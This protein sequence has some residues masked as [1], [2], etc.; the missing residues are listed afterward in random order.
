[1]NFLTD[2]DFAFGGGLVEQTGGRRYKSGPGAKKAIPKKPRLKLRVVDGKLKYVPKKLRKRSGRNIF[3]SEY[4]KKNN[5]SGPALMKKGNKA[6]DDLSKA[7]KQKFEDR[8]DAMGYKPAA[9][10]RQ[11]AQKFARKQSPTRAGAKRRSPTRKSPKRKSKS[12]KR[13]SP[14]RKSKSPKRKSPKRRKSPRRKTPKGKS[15]RKR[16]SPRKQRGGSSCGSDEYQY[17]AGYGYDENSEN[18]VENIGQEDDPMNA[19]EELMGGDFMF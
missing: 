2:Y 11:V 1:M 17:G 7:Q 16:K 14:K 18:N 3:I 9:K 19:I 6:W 8:A 13:K 4:A 12:P 5:V 10:P 15:P